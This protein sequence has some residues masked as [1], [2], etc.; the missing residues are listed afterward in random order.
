MDEKALVTSKGILKAVGASIP[1][2]RPQEETTDLNIL[3]R[4]ENF[5]DN[6]VKNL[7]KIAYNL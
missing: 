2:D 3:A 4:E 1:N 6:E 5:T 7:Q